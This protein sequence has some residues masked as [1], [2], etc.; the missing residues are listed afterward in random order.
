MT[1]RDRKS[2]CTILLDG[3]VR[4]PICRLYFNRAQKYLG[5]FDGQLERLPVDSVNDIF[6][7][8]ARL[9][10]T[11]QGYDNDVDR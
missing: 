6:Q 1:I 5:L 2:Y 3:S 8:S 9:L 4:K 11:V 7:Y 10:A